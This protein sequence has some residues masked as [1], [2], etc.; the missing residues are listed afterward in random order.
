MDT[1]RC[2]DAVDQRDDKRHL[3]CGGE[4]RRLR[5][6]AFQQHHRDGEPASCYTDDYPKRPDHLLCGRLC[7]PHEQQR[8]RQR[9]DARRRYDADDQRER[10]W[11][12]Y[13]ASDGWQWLL[14][15]LCAYGSDRECRACHANRNA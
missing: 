12:L 15:D 1:G 4:S 9:L 11:K 10:E 14:C 13:C 3:F 2:N 5:I 6:R 7:E 8:H